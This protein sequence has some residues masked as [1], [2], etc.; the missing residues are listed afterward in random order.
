[1][2]SDALLR[3]LNYLGIDEATFAVLA[4]LPLVQVAWADGRVQDEERRLILEAAKKNWT[5]SAD[6]MDLLTSWLVHPPGEE[7]LARG[8]R[9]L[10]ALAERDPNFNLE[11]GSLED[12]V[13][14]S[15]QVARAA[16]GFMGFRSIDAS[17]AEIL[18]EIAE[19]LKA[20]GSVAS[21][22]E[23]SEEDV[24]DDATDVRSDEEMQRIREAAD[25]AMAPSQRTLSGEEIADLIH[26]GA[27]GATHF[28]MDG[29]GVTIGRSRTN[30][31]QIP[32]D[33][34]LSRLHARIVVED[35]NFYV[36]DNATT[37]GT[38][39]NGHRVTRRRL[40]G[41]E[42]VRCGDAHFTF[43]VR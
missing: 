37:N 29:D 15:K 4:L 32:H 40:F 26:H 9:A 11:A 38:F 25:I 20:T 31:V 28:V 16:G 24:G 22:F 13:E 42:Q 18:E 27:E 33:H 39:V 1:M 23:D 21:F 10:V 5:L 30:T 12:V 7:Y 36:V 3:E 41:A 14:L 19:T 17:E 2:A 35:G 43:L 34:S 6:A 8:R